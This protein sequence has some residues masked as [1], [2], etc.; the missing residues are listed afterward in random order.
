VPKWNEKD[1]A[2]AVT[3]VNGGMSI[4]IYPFNFSAMD[5]SFQAFA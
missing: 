3:A 4:G 1:M 2:D 5:T